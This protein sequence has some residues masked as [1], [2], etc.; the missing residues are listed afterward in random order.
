MPAP[1]HTGPL[2]PHRAGPVPP[3]A[4]SMAEAQ[5]TSWREL[6]SMVAVRAQTAAERISAELEER[7]ST[8]AVA[9]YLAGLGPAVS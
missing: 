1:R 5:I 8:D 3:Y 2:V 6:P 9:A 7:W 4:C